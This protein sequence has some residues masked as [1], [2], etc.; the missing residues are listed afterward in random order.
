MYSYLFKKRGTQL[1]QSGFYYD[2]NRIDLYLKIVNEIDF[3]SII[4]ITGIPRMKIL[5]WPLVK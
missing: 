1:I 2:F 3:R 5:I 4:L